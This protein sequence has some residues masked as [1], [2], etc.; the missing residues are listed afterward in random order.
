MTPHLASECFACRTHELPATSPTD[1]LVRIC[2]LVDGAL[3]HGDC[4][5]IIDALRSHRYVQV[6]AK[7]GRLAVESVSNGSLGTTCSAEHGL[8]A[9]DEARLAWLGWRAPDD[10]SPNWY[11]EFTEPWPWPA[12]MVAEL[13][14]RTLVE[15]HDVALDELAVTVH[16]AGN[17]GRHPVDALSVEES[18]GRVAQPT[19][20]PHRRSMPTTGGPT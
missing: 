14:V 5:V 16:H 10:Q 15:V 2:S 8:T 18:A 12:S 3:V 20:G 6:L 7:H 13:L 1:L 11:R 19:T 17:G 4:Y 9:D